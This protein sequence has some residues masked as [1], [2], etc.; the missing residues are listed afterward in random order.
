[1]SALPNGVARSDETIK[2][3][4][5][6]VFKAMVKLPGRGVRNGSQSHE[7]T[8]MA[9]TALCIGGMV[10]AR[11]MNRRGLSDRLGEAAAN[12]AVELGG[13]RPM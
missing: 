6:T 8:A 10:A 4:F 3:A 2:A 9:I 5:E 13:W 11:S 12:A 1:M 7:D